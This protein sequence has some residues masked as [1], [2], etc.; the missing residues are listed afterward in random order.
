M[1][2][3]C[4]ERR[5]LVFAVPFGSNLLHE[6]FPGFRIDGV[7]LRVVA[8]CDAQHILGIKIALLGCNTPLEFSETF[9]LSDPRAGLGTDCRTAYDYQVNGILLIQGDRRAEFCR[10]LR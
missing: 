3:Q 2:G 6:S 1:R 10:T 5:N 8:G 9:A 4:P 7:D